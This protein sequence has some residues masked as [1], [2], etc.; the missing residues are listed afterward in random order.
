ML[1]AARDFVRAQQVTSL[2]EV[3]LHL[4]VPEDVAEALLQ[5]W[6]QKGR[7]ERIPSLPK[8]HA[9][10]LCSE[11]AQSLYRWRGAPDAEASNHP[12]AGTNVKVPSTCPAAGPSQGQW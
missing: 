7:I 4:G 6:L 8:C 1:T 12:D 11:A 10:N 5:K 2:R 3:A 9:C